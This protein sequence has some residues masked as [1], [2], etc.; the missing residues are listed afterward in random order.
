MAAHS[1][2]QVVSRAR[3]LDLLADDQRREK[4]F[5]RGPGSFGP[6]FR[7]K[8]TLASRTFT[9]AVRAVA[10][11]DACEYDP[12]LSRASKTG[13]EEMNQRQANLS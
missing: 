13:F 5:E 1:F 7:I 11:D 8:G 4:V 3:I 6:F 9:P 2:H 10:I 12:S